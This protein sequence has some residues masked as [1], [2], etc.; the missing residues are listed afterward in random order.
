MPHYVYIIES[1]VDGTFYKGETASPLQRFNQ[2]NN[3]YNT[4]TAAKAPWRL[5]YLVEVATRTI[6]LKEEKRLKR[7]NKEYLKWLIKQS[8]NLML[9]EAALSRLA[10]GEGVRV[11][12]PHLLNFYWVKGFENHSDCHAKLVSGVW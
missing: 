6:A 11:H 1:L 8:N 3:G 12:F 4:S 10:W 2:H 7:A 9:D 5:I